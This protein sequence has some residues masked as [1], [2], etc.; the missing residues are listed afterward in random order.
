MNCGLASTLMVDEISSLQESLLGNVREGSH[1][2]LHHSRQHSIAVDFQCNKCTACQNNM[3]N[4]CF[5]S[6]EPRG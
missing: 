4:D 3:H 1:E 5:M 2:V 6:K